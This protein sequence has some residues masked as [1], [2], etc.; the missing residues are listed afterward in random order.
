M[1]VC[2]AQRI[3]L[4]D[5]STGLLLVA[6][7]HILERLSCGKF[8]RLRSRNLHLFAGS[9]IAPVARGPRAY[10]ERAEANQLNGI[11]LHERGGDRPD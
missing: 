3:V 11:P 8:H 4:A 10:A 7:H 6:V 9:R 1:T 2:A 5:T